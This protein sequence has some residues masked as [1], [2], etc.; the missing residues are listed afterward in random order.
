MK[1]VKIPRSA[2]AAKPSTQ[3][4]DSKRLQREINQ[5]RHHSPGKVGTLLADALDIFLIAAS[6][7]PSPVSRAKLYRIVQTT[8][9]QT[10]ATLKQQ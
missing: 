7:H 5:L 10:Q 6:L 8:A 9:K 4:I 2:I 1:T 3:H